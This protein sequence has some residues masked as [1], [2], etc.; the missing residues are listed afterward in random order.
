V[1]KDEILR[2]AQNDKE[3]ALVQKFKGITAHLLLRCAQNDKEGA[4]FWLLELC[5]VAAKPS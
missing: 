4:W 3:G 2:Y 5:G 1:L